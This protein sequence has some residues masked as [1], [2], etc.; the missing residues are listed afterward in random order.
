MFLLG[1]KCDEYFHIITQNPKLWITLA[2]ESGEID[3][4][5]LLAYLK[6]E[7]FKSYVL[8]IKIPI[9]WMELLNRKMPGSG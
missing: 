9:K 5:S 1:Y 8:G 4:V 7:C 3:V 2:Q 6:W